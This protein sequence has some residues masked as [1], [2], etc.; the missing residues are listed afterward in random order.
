MTVGYCVDVESAN[1]DIIEW[2]QEIRQLFF[3]KA[4]CKTKFDI[5][6]KGKMLNEVK[7]FTYF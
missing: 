3:I 4:K 5:K 6:I 1:K 7:E 2:F